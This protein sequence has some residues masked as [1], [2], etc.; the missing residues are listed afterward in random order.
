M[1][2][3]TCLRTDIDRLWPHTSVYLDILV[4][5]PGAQ[6]CYLWYTAFDELLSATTCEYTNR[7]LSNLHYEK[8]CE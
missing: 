4:R 2:L 7:S 6:F 3:L 5:E 8:E 1:G